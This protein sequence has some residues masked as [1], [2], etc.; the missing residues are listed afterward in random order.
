MLSGARV[1]GRAAD[2][3]SDDADVGRRPFMLDL[4]EDSTERTFR[5]VIRHR[6]AM[7]FGSR[8]LPPVHGAPVQERMHAAS[9]IVDHS[10]HAKKVSLGVHQVSAHGGHQS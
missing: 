4:R 10:Q 9:W 2:A 8:A 1:S 5:V 6:L 3:E 7:A